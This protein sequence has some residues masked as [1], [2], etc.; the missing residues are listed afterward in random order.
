[1]LQGRS[2]LVRLDGVRIGR[3]WYT[4]KEALQRFAVRLT[5]AHQVGVNNTPKS[6]N[7]ERNAVEQALD[8]L[9]VT[10]VRKQHRV[11]PAN[12]PSSNQ[13]GGSDRRAIQKSLEV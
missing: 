7:Q 9:G 4:S 3:A 1:G 13:E 8:A 10:I 12:G 2:G 5:A 6:A 11:R